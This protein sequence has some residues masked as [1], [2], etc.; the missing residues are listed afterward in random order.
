[1]EELTNGKIS[2]RTQ[3]VSAELCGIR[4]EESGEELMWDADPKIWNRHCPMLFPTVGAVWEGRYE[5]RGVWRSMPKH[6]FLQDTEF[7][8]KEKTASSITYI[9]HDTEETRFI[10]PFKFEL[11]QKFTL[12]GATVRVEWTVRNVGSDDMPFQ[13]GGHP[14]F[15][16]RGFAPGDDVKGYIKFDAPS[17][18]SA[19]VGVGGCLGAERYTLPAPGGLM[20]LRDEVFRVDSIIIDRNQV[21]SIT[22]LDKE[23][24]PVVRVG[25][26]A[27]VFL[28]WSP[29]GV[30]A[31]FVCLEP[32]YGLCDR[33]GFKGEFS[34][35]PYTNVAPAFGEWKGGY[36]IDV[37]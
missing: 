37:L 15:F 34:E 5:H 12:D 27:P 8:V 18:E 1:M 36:E 26:Q 35:R 3:S 22:L 33:E 29:F 14:S 30:E 9:T 19:T 4:N 16:F 21:H 11:E 17:P 20:P 6:G 2:I 10:F 32:W 31:P 25:S 24:E 13:I 7:A 28:V 23:Q